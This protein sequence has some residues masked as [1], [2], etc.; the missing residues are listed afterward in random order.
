MSALLREIAHYAVRF[1]ELKIAIFDRGDE[2][3]RVQQAI[4]GCFGNAE[5]VARI[6]LVILQAEFA[7]TPEDFL[8]VDGVR[9]PPNLQ[10]LDRSWLIRSRY[11]NHERPLML[12]P[13]SRRQLVGQHGWL[14]NL[15]GHGKQLGRVR[16]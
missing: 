10:H 5:L 13:Q 1:P 14:A 6:D 9:A 8:D 7:A 2:S 16:H 15:G 4:F 11:E 3:I 12:R